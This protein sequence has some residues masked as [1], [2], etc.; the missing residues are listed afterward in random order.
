MSQT[1]LNS[2]SRSLLDRE[3]ED[4]DRKAR[5]V[6]DLL[7]DPDQLAATLQSAI[8]LAGLF[9]SAVAAVGASGALTSWVAGFGV[10][11]LDAAMPVLA[12]VLIT[13]VA[14]LL[15]V[16]LGK[17]VPKRIALA[18][19]QKVAKGV[20]GPIAGVQRLMRPFVGLTR[21]C[22][23]LIAGV[24]RIKEPDDSQVSE[25][26]IKYMVAEQEDLSD[27]EKRMIH[28]V[29]DL[30]DTIAREVMIP[31]V[32][33]TA[34]EDVTPIIEVLRIM[35]ETGFT[36]MPVYHEDI[37]WV[38]G[39]VNTKDLIPPALSGS[40]D[41]QVGGYMREAL[42]VPDTK[43]VVPLLSEMK[44][45]RCQMAIVVDEYG[46]TAGIVTAEDIVEEIVGEIQGEYDPEKRTIAKVGEREWSVVGAYPIDDAVELGWPIEANDEYD[47]IAGWLMDEIDKLPEVGDSYE[48][49]GWVFRV[50]AMDDKRISRVRVTAPEPAVGDDDAQIESE[51]Q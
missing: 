20:S 19:P 47:T 23:N 37:D 5:Q 29:F 48:H 45:K 1:A 8:V 22:A 13:L 40:Q 34:V 50:Q 9:A 18:D 26:E 14:A 44:L 42:F 38:T 39:F 11:W 31:R 16:V 41:E 12:P 28:D 25:E 33:V 27:A 36:R 4:G 17:L 30:G 43:D 7:A 51:K 46:G 2:A 6:M 49:E 15:G 35:K 32:D 21:A 3:A 24:L 10:G